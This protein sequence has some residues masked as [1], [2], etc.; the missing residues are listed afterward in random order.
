MLQHDLNSYTVG[1][2]HTK[3]QDK[4]ALKKNDMVLWSAN[5]AEEERDLLKANNLQFESRC[6]IS[7]NVINNYQS[8][9]LC[10]ALLPVVL[11]ISG[12]F[13]LLYLC[14]Y[15]PLPKYYLSWSSALIESRPS[16]TP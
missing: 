15:P 6:N 13:A 3:S 7:S 14:T 5:K 4:N 12:S 11:L 10:N 9:V 16:M 2:A 8:T 1:S